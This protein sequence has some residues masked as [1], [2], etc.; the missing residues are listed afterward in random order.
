MEIKGESSPA[1]KK[2]VI[3][4]S[5]SSEEEEE[6][7]PR[8]RGRRVNQPVKVQDSDEEDGIFHKMQI[9][10]FVDADLKEF[11]SLRKQ[12]KKVEK[13]EDDGS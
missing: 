7:A 6:Q 9:Y 11:D 2:K 10:I 12:V 4:D 13:T 8:R 1:E 5:D 3:D